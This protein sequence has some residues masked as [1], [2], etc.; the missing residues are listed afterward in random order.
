MFLK[1]NE[2]NEVTSYALIGGLSEAVKYDGTIPE[3]FEA[4]FKPSFY[5]IKNNEIVINPE[6]EEPVFELPETQPSSTDK[7][8]AQ[9]LL[10]SAQQKATQDQFN[11]QLLLQLAQ[12][13]GV[14]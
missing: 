7:V 8:V 13:K 2:K 12:I 10:Q 1:T 9:L 11:A 3:C 5:L 14:N 4:N 6:Y